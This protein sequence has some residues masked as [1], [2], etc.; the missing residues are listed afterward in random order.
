[1]EVAALRVS[2]FDPLLLLLFSGGYGPTVSVP[3]GGLYEA[4]T[5]FFAQPEI[6]P[7]WISLSSNLGQK[8]GI[9]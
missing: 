4:T 6:Y 2:G 8:R 1:L 7:S 3:V 9:I 5:P